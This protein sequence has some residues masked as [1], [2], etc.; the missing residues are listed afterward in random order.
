MI[1][2]DSLNSLTFVFPRDLARDA[3][4]IILTKQQVKLRTKKLDF[5]DDNG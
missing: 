1:S 3:E 2:S 4:Y 5:G